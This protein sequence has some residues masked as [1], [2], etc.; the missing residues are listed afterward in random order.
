MVHHVLGYA[1]R[2]NEL[3]GM[4]VRDLKIFMSNELNNHNYCLSHLKTKFVLNS[5]DHLHMIQ[6]V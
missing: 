4:L 1:A 6:T 5:H 2:G 3:L